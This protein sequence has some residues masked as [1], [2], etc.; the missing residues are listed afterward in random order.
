MIT[1][2]PR[3][4]TYVSKK[5]QTAILMRLASA[6]LLQFAL[7]YWLFEVLYAGHRGSYFPYSFRP[8]LVLLRIGLSAGCMVLLFRVLVRGDWVERFM[9]ALLSLLPATIFCVSLVQCAKLVLYACGY[10]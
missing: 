6:A 5:K 9:A 10:G 4:D 3:Q 7:A 8:D 2:A 1:K